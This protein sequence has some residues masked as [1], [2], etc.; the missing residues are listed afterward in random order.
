MGVFW[1]ED[2]YEVAKLKGARYYLYLVD[3]EN[4]R[5]EKYEPMII[6]DPVNSIMKSDNW[7]IETQT[8]HMRYVSDKKERVNK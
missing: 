3:L 2:E 8:Y 7:L 6:C 5:K 1:F 4:I